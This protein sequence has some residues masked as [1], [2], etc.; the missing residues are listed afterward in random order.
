[1]LLCGKHCNRHANQVSLH[2]HERGFTL[3]RI[4][5]SVPSWGARWARSV[6]LKLLGLSNPFHSQNYWEIQRAFIYVG[7]NQ[8]TTLEVRI[9]KCFKYVLIHLRTIRNPPHVNINNTFYE[10]NVFMIKEIEEWHCFTFFATLLNIQLNR[11]QLCSHLCF[12][13]EYTVRCY[14]GWSIWGKSCLP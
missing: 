1:M 10:K 7:C 2:S 5:G 3:P 11:R 14:L 9:E 8:F 13:T 6:V 4:S 12:C